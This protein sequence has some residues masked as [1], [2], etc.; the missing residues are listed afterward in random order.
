[1]SVIELNWPSIYVRSSGGSVCFPGGGVP[2][3]RTVDKERS[4]RYEP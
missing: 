4:F 3:Q 1:M 2:G